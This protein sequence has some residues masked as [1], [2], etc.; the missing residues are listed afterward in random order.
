VEPLVIG[1][2]IVGGLAAVVLGYVLLRPREAPTRPAP[3]ADR[4]AK[5]RETVG[6]RLAVLFGRGRLD[7]VFW[8]ELEE[9]L[10]AA[11]VGASTASE[12]V[13]RVRERRPVDVGEARR[14]LREELRGF[15][16]DL[17]REVRLVHAPG[18]IV[19][20]G[21]N[22]VGKTTSIAKLAAL[23]K[24]EGRDPL[25]GCADTF[26]AA[27]DL[28]L[29]TWA[30]RAGVE[31][32][33]GQA[34]ADPASVAFDAYQAARARGRDVVIIDTAGRLHAKHNLMEEL[35]KL[36][37][38]LRRE[39]GELDE[40]LLVLDAT[41]GQNAI[42]QARDFTQA[43]GVTGIVLT[44][45]DGTARGGVVVAVERELGIPVKLVGVGEGLGDLVPFDPDDFL[46]ALLG[47]LGGHGGPEVPAA[48][49]SSDRRRAPQEER[50]LGGHGGP[51]VPAAPA[52]SDR[53]RA[54]QE[55]RGLGGHGGPEVPAAPASSDRRRAPQEESGERG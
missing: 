41:I 35:A 40:V 21:V 43:V 24:G 17:D 1:L 49:A 34:G 25:L 42:A 16:G 29:R 52:S 53:R 36:T 13:E 55:E 33:S 54:L 45:M 28:Q 14:A 30:E 15:F 19:V 18:V 47:G 39:A 51:E 50:G 3:P 9:T 26:R 32:V 4:F 22:G 44:K 11:D 23:L 27:A 20:V 8:A 2:I 31:M 5:T 38:V 12:V 10:L 37:R 46:E 6:G 48:P 7:D